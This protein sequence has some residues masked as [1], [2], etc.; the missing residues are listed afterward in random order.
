MIRHREAQKQ[1]FLLFILAF[2]CAGKTHAGSVFTLQRHRSGS[3]NGEKPVS[4]DGLAQ[5]RKRDEARHSRLLAAAS[6]NP[7]NFPLGGMA[8]PNLAGLYFTEIEL[9][10]PPTKY[11]V[12][13]DTGSDL[14]WVNCASCKT[15]PTSTQLGVR[16]ALYDP[17]SSLSSSKV[18]CGDVYCDVASSGECQTADLCGYQLG[19]GDG[20]SSQGYFVRDALQ[21][22]LVFGNIST[23]ANATVAFGCGISQGGE[24]RNSDQALDGII[25]FGQSNLSVISQLMNQGRASGVFAHCLD[26]GAEG[27]GILVIGEVKASGLVHTPILQ[28]QPHY[29][30]NLKSISVN[31]ASIPIDSS[32][33]KSGGTIIDSGTTLAYFSDASYQLLLQA[34]FE[35]VPMQMA[36]FPWEGMTCVPY[37][38]SVDDVFPSVTLNFDGQG[39][40]MVIKPHDYLIQAEGETGKGWCIGFQTP[41]SN[42]LNLNIIGDL[43]LK[44][45]LVVYDLQRQQIGWTNYDCST[46]VSVVTSTGQVEQIFASSI[47]T[48]GCDTYGWTFGFL[49]WLSCLHVYYYLYHS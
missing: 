14:L 23:V 32:V 41:G 13:V 6:A 42:N 47:P 5:T 20:S 1:C 49:L 12:Q 33:S 25:G 34:I 15:C 11:Y 37:L 8:D 26:G 28:K 36:N 3:H 4:L 30:V 19:Y 39:A 40:V 29:N 22:K 2:C 43:V 48:S 38:T 21:L 18:L 44:D 16:L 27:G 46:N 7:S 31:G 9:G 17:D 45:R 10:T 24:L 35:A